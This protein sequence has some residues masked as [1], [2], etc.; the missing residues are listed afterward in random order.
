[1]SEQTKTDEAG[2]EQTGRDEKGQFTKDNRF[3]PGNPF[4]RQM[5]EVRKMILEEGEEGDLRLVVKKLYA[6]AKEGDIQ[7][8]KVLLSYTAGKPTPCPDPDTLDQQELTLVAQTSQAVYPAMK[9]AEAMSPSVACDL[10]RLNR[11]TQRI[12]QLKDIHN[13][14][15]EIKQQKA[16]DTTPKQ[17]TQKKTQPPGDE[18]PSW[19]LEVEPGAGLR[20]P[21]VLRQLEAEIRRQAALRRADSERT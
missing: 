5:A 8:I 18:V 17:R 3:G 2:Q 19:V 9:T 7:A 20:D 16:K 10:L 21:E 13:Q 15:Q 11:Y 4:A 1:M 6:M 12:T 14:M